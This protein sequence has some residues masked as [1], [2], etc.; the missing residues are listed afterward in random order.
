MELT[1]I[2]LNANTTTF[3]TNMPAMG[4]ARFKFSGSDDANTLNRE[5]ITDER[6]EMFSE[7]GI[8]L[9]ATDSVTAFSRKIV[10]NSLAAEFFAPLRF[11]IAVVPNVDFATAKTFTV[12][13][14]QDGTTTTALTDAEAWIEVV[15]PDDTTS[16]FITETDKAADN[17][18]TADQTSSSAS[19]TGL[20]S[21]TGT[22]TGSNNASVLTDSGASF[23]TN[24]LIGKVVE[25]TTDGS[26]GTITA[27]TATT[28]TATLSG[29]NDN[30]WDTSDAY[31]IETNVKQKCAVTTS[32][33]GKKGYAKVYFCLATDATQTAYVDP[34]PV[35]T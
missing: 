7:T 9:D 23:T 29:G 6:G 3:L 19:W 22:H 4:G 32:A 17:Q 15:F 24:E 16:A 2:R 8:Y 13:F 33:T 11:E 18:T 35:V 30:D 14:C 5:Y 20:S 31:T 21:A 10:S 25:N 12:E 34:L 28:V 1:R 26:S 27:N